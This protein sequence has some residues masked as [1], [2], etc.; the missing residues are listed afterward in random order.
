MGQCMRH[1]ILLIHGIDVSICKPYVQVLDAGTQCGL[2]AWNCYS[3]VLRVPDKAMQ[4]DW[5]EIES[6]SR[7]VTPAVHVTDCCNVQ[8]LL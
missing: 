8:S 1:S 6:V 5:A 4:N 2:L 3:A 7:G